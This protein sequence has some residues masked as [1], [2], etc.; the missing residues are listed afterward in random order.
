MKAALLTFLLSATV[1]Q[2]VQA[3]GDCINQI[4]TPVMSCPK[5]SVIVGR[6]TYSGNPICHTKGH[7]DVQLNS[8]VLEPPDL[9]IGYVLY[10]VAGGWKIVSVGNSVGF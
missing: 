6:E 4:F 8:I 3:D 9:P 1:T 10:R 7:P 5:G 2:P